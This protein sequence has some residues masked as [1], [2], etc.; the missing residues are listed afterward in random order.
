MWPQDVNDVM[1][2][3]HAR[4]IW[5]I[6]KKVSE[7]SFFL[8]RRWLTFGARRGLGQMVWGRWKSQHRKI[9]YLPPYVEKPFNSKVI[10]S[11]VP[12]LK[13]L[14]CFCVSGFLCYLYV[15]YEHSMYISRIHVWLC[16]SNGY[17]RWF[18]KLL[19]SGHL[20]V[21]FTPLQRCNQCILQP[22]LIGI[23]SQWKINTKLHC[24]SI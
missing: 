18:P 24:I 7:L 21:G 4:R 8:G 5:G 11:F 17:R 14:K 2:Q 10:K 13:S 3:K 9:V 16:N 1:H 15:C 20:L 19:Y 22:Q 23:I 12:E 6:W